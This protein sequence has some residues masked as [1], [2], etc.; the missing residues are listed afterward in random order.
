MTVPGASI[1]ASLLGREP[2]RLED[3]PWQGGA[4]FAEEDLA[5]L[6]DDD[7]RALNPGA[8]L[9]DRAVCLG[10]LPAFVHDQ[11]KGQ[12][13][14]FDKRAVAVGIGRVYP[15]RND[16]G[17]KEPFDRRANGGQLVPSARGHIRGVED[18]QDVAVLVEIAE[19]ILVAL[20]A[21]GV[22]VGSE[23]ADLRRRTR[24]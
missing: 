16:A 20:G 4:G 11:I 24:W 10:N 14:F 9:L 7:D 21:F 18:Q 17:L 8:V 19:S 5:T 13:E 2:D 15:K 12:V 1:A 23:V 3:V 6:T 22:E